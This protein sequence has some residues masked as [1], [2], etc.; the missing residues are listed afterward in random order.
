MRALVLGAVYLLYTFV[1][2]GFF[3]HRCAEAQLGPYSRKYVVFLAVLGSVYFIPPLIRQFVRRHGSKRLVFTLM[4]CLLLG[5]MVYVVAA[6]RYY[7]TQTHEFDP[8]LQAPPPALEAAKPGNTIRVLALGGSTTRNAHLPEGERYPRVLE[9]LLQAAYPESPVQVLNAGMDWYT[10]KHLLINYVTNVRETQP[11]LVVIMEA[12]NDLYRSFSD[13]GCALGPYDR[14][15]AHFYGPSI[16]GAKPPAFEEHLF[17]AEPRTSG[18]AASGWFSELRVREADLPL[19]RYVSLPDFERNLRALIHYVRLDR[20]AVVLMTQPSLFQDEMTAEER[21]LLWFGKRFCCEGSGWFRYRYPSPRSLWLAMEGYNRK[22]V[23]VAREEGVP[24]I[25]VACQVPRDKDHFV[26][27]V[28]YTT[29]GARCVAAEA[30]RGIVRQKLLT[31]ALA[32]KIAS[33][34]QD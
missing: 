29:V 27:D 10:T 21:D 12:I 15:Y 33:Q 25:D 13:P 17:A 16:L 23:E 5:L 6:V 18:P 19:E 20:C 31:G 11:D 30:A 22:I 34:P 3:F 14:Q 26:D 4:P 9:S 1:Y 8:F 28:H 32:G 7:Y 2:A 24:V